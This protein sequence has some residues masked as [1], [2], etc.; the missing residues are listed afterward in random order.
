MANYLYRKHGVPIQF[1]FFENWTRGTSYV[2][3]ICLCEVLWCRT[4]TKH[5][6]VFVNMSYLYWKKEQ[7]ADNHMLSHL[8]EIKWYCISISNGFRK[9]WKVNIFLKVYS[10]RTL[11]IRH[12]PYNKSNHISIESVICEISMR[13]T[14]CY[15]IHNVVIQ[16]LV[17]SYSYYGSPVLLQGCK[18]IG[19]Y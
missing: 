8:F 9:K 19:I 11:C 5:K 7:H 14:G 10:I 12:R 6:N 17:D 3:L 18:K 2:K 4:N 15:T 13:G 16:V 1:F